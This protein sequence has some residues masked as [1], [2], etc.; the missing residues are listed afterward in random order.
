V[1][2]PDRTK[3]KEQV[4]QIREATAADLPQIL[5]IYNDVIKNSTAIY[6]TAPATIADRAAWL[7]A[8][9]ERG[10]PVL[11]AAEEDL[12]IGY[13]SF[14]DWRGAW[15]GYRYTVEHSVHVRADRRGRGAGADLV[16][17]LFPLALAMNMHVMIGAI[18]AANEGSLRFHER[19]GF[20]RAAHFKEVG[21]KFG[22]WLDLV[23]L[24][25]ILDAQGAPR[26]AVG[27]PPRAD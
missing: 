18:D 15:S 6:A 26:G 5:A 2:A 12:V 9:R 16:A 20:Q 23:F 4:M 13:S 25:K 3:S 21:H 24:Q 17:A 1:A 19:L 11:V 10:Y 8:R 7:Q 22:R 14:G 27:G